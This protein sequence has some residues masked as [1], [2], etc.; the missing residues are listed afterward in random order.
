MA[1]E[2][3]LRDYLKRVM[4]DLHDTRR[5]LSEAQ[6]QELEP[7][8]IVAMSCRLPGGVRNPDDL[9]ELL[10]E[11]RDAVAPFPGDRGWDLERLYHPDPDHPGTSYAREG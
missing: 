7:V 4:A 11:G 10:R 3:K 8:A 1:N 6:S 5:R 9:W 2:D